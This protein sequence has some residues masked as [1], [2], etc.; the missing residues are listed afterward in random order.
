M[1]AT[2]RFV[3]D[4]HAG[5]VLAIAIVYVLSYGPYLAC[6]YECP[7]PMAI[8][9]FHPYYDMNDEYFACTTH[10]VYQPVEY[11]IDSTCLRD[12]LIAWSDVWGARDKTENDSIFRTSARKWGDMTW[13][14]LVMSLEIKNVYEIA[15]EQS[16][17]PVR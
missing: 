1:T 17:A 9:R 13:D 2:R 7:I 5:V 16:D 15:S 6:R 8:G 14:E 11:L 10:F 12:L 4:A 3:L